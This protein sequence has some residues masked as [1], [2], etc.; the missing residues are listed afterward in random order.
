MNRLLCAV[1]IA[2]LCCCAVAQADVFH[3]GSGLTSLDM[4]TVGDPGNA[5]ELSGASVPGGYGPDRVCGAV[6]YTYSIGKYEVTAAQYCEFLNCK[7]KSDPHLLWNSSMASTD[8]SIQRSGVSGSYTYTVI[9][10]RENRAIN[11]VYYW[12]ACR[13]VNWLGNGQGN[14]DTEN[15]AYDLSNA[16]SFLN[17]VSD[18]IQRNPGAK[19][20]L[21]SEDE[22][23]KAAY[24]KGGSADAGYWDYATQSDAQPTISY[25]SPDSGNTASLIGNHPYDVGIHDNSPSAYGTYDQSGNVAEFND[26]VVYYN[27]A[28]SLVPAR[29]LRGAMALSDMA[30]SR[31]WYSGTTVG[32]YNMGFRVA[33]VPEPS[34]LIGLAGG[35]FGLWSLRRRRR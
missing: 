20:V 7:A 26:T 10:G 34:S 21:P 6:D 15:G 25:T 17:P 16:F 11:Y 35:L 27:Y 22:W 31:R 28:G 4:V 24:Y 5:G 12:S 9:S 13:F 8:G 18:T 29:G 3:L 33:Y 19:W 23:Y 2:M 32:G 14:G 30:A 1:I